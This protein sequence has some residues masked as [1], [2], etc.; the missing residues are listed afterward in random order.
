MTKLSD[1][2]SPFPRL[3]ALIGDAPPGLPPIDMAIGEPRHAMPDGFVSEIMQTAAGFGKYP[4]IA[5]NNRVRGAISDWH[6]RRYGLPVDSETELIVLNG[7]R[8]GLASAIML[9]LAEGRQHGRRKIAMPNPF[10]QVY[11]GAALAAGGEPVFLEAGPETGHLPDVAALSDD[12]AR[13]RDVAALIV[14]SPANPQGAMMPAADIVAL[15]TACRTAG[16]M[17]FMDECYSEI[18]GAAPPAGAL[19]SVAQATQSFDNVIAFNSLSKRSNVPGLRSGFAAGDAG[20]LARLTQLRNVIAPQ[21]PLPIQDASALL[22]DEEDHVDASRALYVAK[23]DVADRLLTGHF[24]Y[25]RPAGGFFLWLDMTRFGDGEAATLTIWK[26]C[27]VKVLPGAYLSASDQDG[28]NPGQGFV[29]VALVH[30]L[31]TTE[32]ALTRL[33]SL[34]D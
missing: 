31:P 14:C 20:F 7:S 10:Y 24:G 29:R 5:G 28:R 16:C 3:R 33:A 6:E 2:R 4:P 15:A 19:V 12:P 27:G 21:V 25:A 13:L 32:E 11:A 1:I 26:R 23:L 8:E 17:L 18:Y 34:D 22:W 30:D 9:A